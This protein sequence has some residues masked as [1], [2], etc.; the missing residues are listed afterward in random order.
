[1]GE[2]IE[3]KAGSFKILR[4]DHIRLDIVVLLALVSNPLIE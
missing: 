2:G 3:I 1:M 4:H